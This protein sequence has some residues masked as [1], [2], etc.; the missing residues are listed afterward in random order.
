MRR[1]LLEVP[2]GLTAEGR[3]QISE[4]DRPLATI[5]VYLFLVETFF[6]WS[7]SLTQTLR[8]FILVLKT[9]IILYLG[10]A[11]WNNRVALFVS[12]EKKNIVHLYHA[13]VS[14]AKT[15]VYC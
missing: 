9:K 3:Y 12:S 15:L 13:C 7:G 6:D 2:K 8:T 5:E 1:F 4:T 14:S 10:C 11:D